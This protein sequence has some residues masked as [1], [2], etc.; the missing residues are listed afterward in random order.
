M[1]GVDTGRGGRSA[2]LNWVRLLALSCLGWSGLGDGLCSS[3]AHD[4]IYRNPGI[5]C[6]SAP[7]PAV[8]H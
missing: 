3:V 6:V 2:G 8:T 4:C 7:S 1:G 5:L